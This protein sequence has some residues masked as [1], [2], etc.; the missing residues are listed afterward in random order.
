MPT[1]HFHVC[2]NVEG[3]S[4][5]WTGIEL[6]DVDTARREALRFAGERLIDASM[7][8]RGV[9]GWN[10][11]VTDKIGGPVFSL[12]FAMQP[13]TETVSKFDPVMPLGHHIRTVARR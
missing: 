9:T 4:P 3:T 8:D 5:D 11:E 13:A 7:R 6:D 2:D 1:Y 10:I 12:S